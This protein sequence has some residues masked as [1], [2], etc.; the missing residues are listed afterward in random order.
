MNAN[1]DVNVSRAGF[2]NVP[3]TVLVRGTL[4]VRMAVVVRWLAG[5]LVGRLGRKGR[6]SSRGGKDGGKMAARWREYAS[7]DE[8][9]IALQRKN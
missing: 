3:R 2:L 4:Y 5:L 1:V 7:D 8:L 9:H 6:W